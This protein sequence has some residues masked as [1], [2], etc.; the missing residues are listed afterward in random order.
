NTNARPAAAVKQGNSAERP[1]L[2]SA[3]AIKTASVRTGEGDAPAANIGRFLVQPDDKLTSP[4]AASPSNAAPVTHSIPTGTS[5]TSVKLPTGVV[6][7]TASTVADI[8][9]PPT[10]G[11]NRV[12]QAANVLAAARAVGSDHH[13]ATLQLDPPEL[14]QI[15][16]DIRLHDQGMA[17]RVDAQSAATAKLV[18]SRLPELRDALAIHG[19][20]VDDSQVVVRTPDSGDAG[21]HANSHRSDTGAQEQQNSWFSGGQSPGS[22][23]E[24][25]SWQSQPQTAP[26]SQEPEPVLIP[27]TRPGEISDRYVNLVA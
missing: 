16:I 3:V 4:G 23:P 17:L 22:S 19:I 12:E 2:E 21:N 8:L 7:T 5:T 10:D 25:D 14:G 13:Q 6:S 26:T 18:E 1:A 20:R 15:R 11:L 9:S 27:F 24:R